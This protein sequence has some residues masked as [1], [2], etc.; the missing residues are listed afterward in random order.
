MK[1]RDSAVTL[2]DPAHAVIQAEL[3]ARVHE[4]MKATGDDR[5]LQ[6]DVPLSNDLTQEQVAPYLKDVLQPLAISL[7]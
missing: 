3:Y 2:A 1:Q 4:Y 6:M 7:A 5:D